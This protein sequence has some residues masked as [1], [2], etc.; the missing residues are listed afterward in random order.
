MLNQLP[1]DAF[2]VAIAL[3]PG[4]EKARLELMLVQR[5]QLHTL[6]VE[7]GFDKLL[8]VTR[9]LR[10]AFWTCRIVIPVWP[11]ACRRTF[12]RLPSLQ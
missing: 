6:P 11:L 1:L 7:I 3:V 8:E 9:K 12:Q 10:L 5:A 4:A 2:T